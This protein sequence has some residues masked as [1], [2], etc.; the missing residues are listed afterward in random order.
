M[1]QSNI[2]QVKIESRERL[3]VK[4]AD[5]K[6]SDPFTRRRS[7]KVKSGGKLAA[8][9][10]LLASLVR[11]ALNPIFISAISLYRAIS[12]ELSSLAVQD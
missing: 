3:G 4:R 10:P 11:V 9:A 1:I 7:L 5:S 8:S 6:R 12:S 2:A